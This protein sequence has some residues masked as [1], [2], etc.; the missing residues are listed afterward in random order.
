MNETKG[1]WKE[2]KCW[3]REYLKA[4]KKDLMEKSAWSI[5]IIS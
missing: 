3:Q 1:G 4:M 5:G 2:Q